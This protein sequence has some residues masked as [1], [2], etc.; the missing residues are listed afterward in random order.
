[1]VPERVTTL[2]I[3]PDACPYSAE[4]WLDIT[5][6]SPIASGEK[7]PRKSF[8]ASRSFETPSMSIVFALPL[9][10]AAEMFV[11]SVTLCVMPGA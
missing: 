6:Y 10:P 7:S 2:M 11:V 1:L 3:A 5:W 8:T 9:L 4:Y